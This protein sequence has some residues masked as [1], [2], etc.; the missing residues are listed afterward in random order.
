MGNYT[1]LKREQ[2]AV[3]FSGSDSALRIQVL[4]ED[5][6]RIT[7]SVKSRFILRNEPMI[8]NSEPITVKWSLIDS[9]KGYLITTPKVHVHLSHEGVLRY[10][11]SDGELLTQEPSRSGRILREIDIVQINYHSDALIETVQGVDGIRQHAQGVPYIDRKGVQTRLSFDFQPGEAIYGL[12]QHEEG[13]LNY[14]GQHQFLYQHNL[15]IA[16][17]V[18][19]SSNGWGIL[20]NSCSAMT[21]HDDAMGSY[22]S[23]DADEEMDFFF[24]YGPNFDTMIASIRRLTGDAP[25]LPKWAFGYIQSK[26]RYCTQDELLEIAREYRRRQIPLDLIVQDWQSWEDGLWGQKTVDVERYPCLKDCINELH[27]MNVKLMV[28]I[29]PHMQGDG[30][31]RLEMLEKGLLLGNRSTYDAFSDEARK[32]YWRQ[33]NEG[34]FSKGVDAWWCDCSEPFEADWHGKEPMIPENRM[35]LN[36]SEA[37][38][39]LDPSM[40]NA[41]SLLHSKGIW[42]GQREK[43][44]QKRVFNLTRSGYP[45]QQ[46]YGTAVWNGDVSATWEN[47]RRSIADGLNLCLSGQPYWHFDI[48]GFF[49]GRWEDCWFARG[50]YNEGCNDP[51]YRELYLRWFQTGAFLP[52]F[53]SHGT[54]TP[55]EVWRFGDIGDE[56]YEALADSIRLR[57]RLLPYIYSLCASVFYERDTIMRMLA[58]DFRKDEKVFNIK[59]QFMLGRGLMVCPVMRP[60]AKSRDVYLPEGKDWFDFHTGK[61]YSG[62]QT[63][64]VE[65]PLNKIPLFV[66]SG[67]IIPMGI[68]RQ[69][70]L[71]SPDAPITLRVYNGADSEFVLYE[72]EGDGYG[73]EQGEYAR[74]SIHW[75]DVSGNLTVRHEGEYP[76]MPQKRRF[77]LLL[78]C[79]AEIVFSVEKKQTVVVSI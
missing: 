39:Y 27:N 11:T 48:G 20:Y 46:R 47:L 28:S 42:E 37:K 74:Y 31:N 45:G 52:L 30:A 4:Q 32:V 26:E 71:E 16:C 7:A 3:V 17:P 76:N 55:R 68:V 21:F 70:A 65:T 79:G 35:Q 18:L 25:M 38:A 59:T 14:R 23:S 66:P 43:S 60:N 1:L 67:S 56:I 44:D 78:P 50:E 19:M 41:Y 22:L 33:A 51:A 29:W 13:V 54:N 10:E 69:H 15:K 61:R 36:V 53:R 8:I 64:T 62:G 49:S 58:F 2:S 9:E 34:L 40:I 24:L 73:Y 75:E 6:L 57:M 72:D 5:L 77:S 63:I 12:G